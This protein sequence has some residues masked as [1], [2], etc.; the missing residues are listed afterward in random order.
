M[1]VP[2]YQGHFGAKYSRAMPFS[3]IDK[4]KLIA[5]VR[6]L[7]GDLA[8]V[9]GIERELAAVTAGDCARTRQ[10]A[11]IVVDE[12]RRSRHGRGNRCVERSGKFEPEPVDIESREGI[13]GCFGEEGVGELYKRFAAG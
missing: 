4:G 2:N 13:R 10:P 6:Q 9:G 7:G 8:D 1:N 11:V 5:H 3:R 12:R